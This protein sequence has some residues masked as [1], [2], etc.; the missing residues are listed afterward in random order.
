MGFYNFEVM[1]RHVTTA[2]LY[3]SWEPFDWGRRRR[4]VAE[5]ARGVEQARR[6]AEQTQSRVAVEVG[7]RYREWRQAA[8]L[9]E[10]TRTTSEAARE[11]LRVTADKY[12]EE[13][14][15]LKDLLDVQARSADADARHQ[16]ALSSY[17]SAMA[18]LRR[19]T[20]DE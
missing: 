14:A 7:V 1:P 6:S 11:Q 17:W 3:I 2:G 16:G 12:R 5:K 18:D 15:L 8:L 19:A 10:A 20:G 13:A 9:L 4:K